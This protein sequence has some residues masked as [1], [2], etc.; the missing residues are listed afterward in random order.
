MAPHLMPGNEPASCVMMLELAGSRHLTTTSNQCQNR[1]CLY[2][3]KSESVLVCTQRG[4]A[5]DINVSAE[6]ASRSHCT[7]SS[8][9][10]WEACSVMPSAARC[11]QPAHV[12]FLEQLEQGNCLVRPHSQSICLL[13]KPSL[14]SLLLKAAAATSRGPS[15]ILMLSLG[16]CLVLQMVPRSHSDQAC[17]H[18][19]SCQ[20]ALLHRQCSALPR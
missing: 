13:S 18:S 4:S 5:T 15:V 6:A 1:H 14:L 7:R 19:S 3:H 11:L 16:H 20:P 2:C 8:Q 10:S 12:G 17:L 9:P